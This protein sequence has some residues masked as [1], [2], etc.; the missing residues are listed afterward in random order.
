M[1]DPNSHDLY[2]A[3]QKAT[4]QTGTIVSESPSGSYGNLWLAMTG[5]AGVP[6]Q[7]DQDQKVTTIAVDSSARD[8]IVGTDG[9]VKSAGYGA[10]N[11][12]RLNNP[13]VLDANHHWRPWVNGL[14]VPTQKVTWITGQY[15]AGTYYYYMATWG[16]GIWKREARGGD[17]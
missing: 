2:V 11:V 5:A 1:T 14:P 9:T 8:L 10:A 6:G 13:G 16:R 4:D 15:E 3:G 7:L 17:L 12:W